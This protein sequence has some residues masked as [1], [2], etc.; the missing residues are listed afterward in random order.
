MDIPVQFSRVK[1]YMQFNRRGVQEFLLCCCSKVFGKPLA[2]NLEHLC[3][4]IL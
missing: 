3:I 2:E 4:E 1:Q